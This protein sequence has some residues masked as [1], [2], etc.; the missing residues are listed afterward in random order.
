MRSITQENNNTNLTVIDAVM[1][2][3]KTTFIINQ[4]NENKDVNYIYITPNLSECD[5]IVRACP[6]LDFK[7]PSDD[8][9]TKLKDL[10]RLV[11]TEENIVSTHAL[12]THFTKETLELLRN[13][14]YHLILDEAIVPCMKH[15][16]SDNDIDVLLKSGY[17]GL[18]NDGITLRWLED[19][20]KYD[21]KYFYEYKLIENEN[22]V[23]FDFNQSKKEKKVFI[24][25]LTPS[26]FESFLDVT[27]LTYQFEGSYLRSYLDVKGI[28]YIID[29]DTIKATNKIGH[30]I[31]IC[32]HKELNKIGTHKQSLASSLKN[33][34]KKCKQLGTNISNY[35]RNIMKAKA[36][37]ILCTT[38]KGAW[39][40]VKGKGYATT[41]L[42][43]NT[44]ATNDYAHKTVLVY[45]LNR[46]MDVPVKQYL[47]SQGVDVNED[48]WALNEMLQWI[49]RSA[50]RN[51]KPIDIYV[52]SR[53]MREL[54][55]EWCE[56]N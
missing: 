50:I 48:L 26:L 14:N 35:V 25:E 44:K 38:F 41:F 39:K 7:H 10:Q 40:N 15:I 17:V 31:N 12:L 32:E 22:L 46:Y 1:G 3:G 52:P 34:P 24:W 30:L 54:L 23:M 28:S 51:G 33:D 45:G 13:R 18:S 6:E 42:S 4:M 11:E 29:T 49:F 5:R 19:K 43:H 56:H 36:N 16:I 37:E 27:I 20:P 2:S 21:F 8:K 9:G 47:V 55:L 53:R